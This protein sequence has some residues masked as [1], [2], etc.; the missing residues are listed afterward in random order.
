[1]VQV[2]SLG[3]IGSRPFAQLED[4]RLMA[5]GQLHSAPSTF[6]SSAEI[7]HRAGSNRFDVR[8]ADGPSDVRTRPPDIVQGGETSLE[9]PSWLVRTRIE[10]AAAHL[11]QPNHLGC[12]PLA[13]RLSFKAIDESRTP[14]EVLG[15]PERA[16][17]KV[18]GAAEDAGVHDAGPSDGLDDYAHPHR[19]CVRNRDGRWGIHH[20]G[21]VA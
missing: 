9:R 19:R 20:D 16:G 17:S 11:D 3:R 5:R 4:R 6:L 2:F 13:S 18:G 10:D 7:A 12:A 15:E 1:M 21:L 14:R 8:D